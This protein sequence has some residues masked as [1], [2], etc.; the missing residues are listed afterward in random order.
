MRS[1]LLAGV[2]VLAATAA[3]PAANLITNGGFESVLTT[4]GAAASPGRG[5]ELPPNF[6]APFS[7]P[8]WTSSNSATASGGAFNLWFPG[9]VAAATSAA[10]GTDPT[11]RFT[12]SERQNLANGSFAPT[13][14]PGAG[15]AYTQADVL[16]VGTGFGAIGLSPAG[17]AFVALDGDTQFNGPLSQTVSGLV[18]GQAYLL[19]FAWAAGMFD[20]R[21]EPTYAAGLSI[22]NSLTVSLGTDSFTT[23]TVTTVPGQFTGWFSVSRIFTASAASETL[24]FLSIGAPN[25]LPPVALLDGVSL[26]AVPVPAS[27]LLFGIGL[28]GLGVSLN[29]RRAPVAP[30]A[31][32]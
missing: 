10:P 26:T 28:L 5:F 16:A 14:A 4:A 27:A 17:G 31:G 20:N 9:S 8:G 12:A 13:G 7:L 2:A 15:A 11:T 23:P 24:S 1:F 6:A 32:G 19:R 25:G 18:P 29:G 3:A 21:V 22:Q 30:V